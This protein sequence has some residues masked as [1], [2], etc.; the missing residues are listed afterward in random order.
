MLTK[1]QYFRLPAQGPDTYFWEDEEELIMKTLE[2]ASGMRTPCGS[3]VR[4]F[5]FRV[6]V[7]WPRVRKFLNQNCEFF[8]FFKKILITLLSVK[9]SQKLMFV[10]HR[11]E[12]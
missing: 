5:I 7:F 12:F 1:L 11:K 2:F 6:R 8:L 4:K 9:R 10:N 3:R